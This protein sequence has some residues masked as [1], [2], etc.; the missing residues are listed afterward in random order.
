MKKRTGF[1]AT[2]LCL[3]LILGCLGVSAKDSETAE[4]EVNPFKIE[5]TL[6]LYELPP[7]VLLKTDENGKEFGFEPATGEQVIIAVRADGSV[8][9]MAEYVDE[10]NESRAVLSKDNLLLLKEYCSNTKQDLKDV[11]ETIELEKY[12]V[13]GDI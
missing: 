1:T 9:P 8:M 12:F 11:K 4:K 2:A 13:K 7:E 3:L 6:C 5:Y 10:V